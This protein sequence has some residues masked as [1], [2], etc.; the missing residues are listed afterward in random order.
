MSVWLRALWVSSAS[1]YRR[2]MWRIDCKAQYM[3]EKRKSPRKRTGEE[4]NTG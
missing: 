3:Q 4:I 1:D 2:G